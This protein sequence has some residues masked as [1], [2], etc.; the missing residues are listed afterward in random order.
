MRVAVIGSARS[1]AH[2][3]PWNDRSLQK[4]G[5]AWLVPLM[6]YCDLSFE[7]HPARHWNEGKR[8]T[9]YYADLNKRGG[10]VVTTEPHDGLDNQV[11]FDWDE[12]AERFGP[13][14]KYF[15]SSVGYMIAHAIL[16][17]ATE[18]HVY[19]VDMLAASEYGYQRANCEWWL[20]I[21][22]G[23]GIK[24]V[25]PSGSALC[26]ANHLYGVEPRPEPSEI[27]SAWLEGQQNMYRELW[28]AARVEVGML[29]GARREVLNLVEL[30]KTDKRIKLDPAFVAEHV[31]GYE[32]LIQKNQG[33]VHTLSGSMQGVG[34]V[35]DFSRH[36]DR[37]GVITHAHTPQKGKPNEMGPYS[38]DRRIQGSAGQPSE[39]GGGKSLEFRT[40]PQ[41]N[42]SRPRKAATASK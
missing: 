17:G 34:H 42:G 31:K 20:G 36:H 37:G 15:Q 19:A 38:V 25:L 22:K 29:E 30:A 27:H 8:I 14:A 18:L 6:P 2:Q 23:L 11:Q 4:W 40:G 1:S 41:S 3:V 35:L 5:L 9:N 21:A 26:Q 13:E 24:V 16:Q 12:L 7:V 32:G 10:P 33:R 28:E 39:D